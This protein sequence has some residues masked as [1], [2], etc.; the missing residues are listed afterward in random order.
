MTVFHGFQQDDADGR[1][2]GLLTEL[3]HLLAP[4]TVGFVGELIDASESPIALDMMSEMLSEAGS[5]L[6]RWVVDEIA[7]LASALGLGPDTAGRLAPF[8]RERRHEEDV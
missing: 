3:S 6:D 1:L 2:R 8:V 7:A 4:A 5:P